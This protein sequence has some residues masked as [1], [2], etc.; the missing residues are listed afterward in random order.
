[1]WI[2]R[3][4]KE[5]KKILNRVLRHG[6]LSSKYFIIQSC[7][8]ILFFLTIH[9]TFYMGSFLRD[10]Y[11]QLD[12]MIMNTNIKIITIGWH[13]VA[14]EAELDRILGAISEASYINNEERIYEHTHTY[15]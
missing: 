12:R 1:M 13:K 2:Q 5:P 3:S 6:N 10:S 4:A 8:G 11:L 15:I 7:F 14:H 9:P